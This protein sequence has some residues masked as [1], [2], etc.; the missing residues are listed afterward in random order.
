M[1]ILRKCQ[2]RGALLPGKYSWRRGQF[3]HEI[4]TDQPYSIK[5]V[6]YEDERQIQTNHDPAISSTS[7]LSIIKPS[8]GLSNLPNPII[9][10]C[11]A[12]FAELFL[13]K[14]VSK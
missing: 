7:Y 13:G 5:N 14:Y 12:V 3:L 6:K 9:Q 10:N 4:P 1:R 8:G 11:F 2:V